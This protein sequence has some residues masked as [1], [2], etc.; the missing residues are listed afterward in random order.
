MHTTP[1]P[2][3]FRSRDSS[4]S[5]V[6]TLRVARPMNRAS[7]RGRVKRHS[8]PLQ[9]PGRF[10]G[11]STFLHNGYCG[12]LQRGSSGLRAHQ[13]IQI[14]IAH[15][16]IMRR[17]ISPLPIRIN[18]ML[19]NE[20]IYEI[21]IL[22]NTTPMCQRIYRV[23]KKSSY[24]C[25]RRALKCTGSGGSPIHKNFYRW[26]AWP[27]TCSCTFTVTSNIT[28]F[29][30]VHRDFWLTLYIFEIVP[31]LELLPELRVSL[32]CNMTPGK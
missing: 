26:Y 25:T 18:D 20:R 7:I 11:S 28:Y 22:W 4:I 23:S 6:T 31:H 3:F 29:R 24:S 12:L 1:G 17:A 27:L 15:G 19:R 21:Y 16:F 8:L 14:H 9:H 32:F 30:Q 2:K 10:W 13:P 5:M